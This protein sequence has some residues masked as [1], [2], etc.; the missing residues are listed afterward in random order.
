MVCVK[1]THD[2]WRAASAKDAYVLFER[3]F[4][5]LRVRD[6]FSEEEM[7]RFA[8]EKP[9]SF[10]P[11]ERPMSL[12]GMF[13]SENE[14]S[15]PSGVLFL[16]DSA[17][18]FPPDTA[19]GIN[20]ALEDVRVLKRVLED[21]GDKGSLTNALETYEKR[22]DG[23]IWELM[24]LAEKSSPYQYQQNWMGYFGY[25]LNKTVRA[26]LSGFAPALFHPDADTLI[27]QDYEYSQVRRL[28]DSTTRNMV[29]LSLSLVALPL[30]NMVVSQ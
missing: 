1:P 30:M 10:S 18:S 21:V 17:H 12:V 20:C 24:R 3:N 14:H 29:V 26:T 4:P 23:E 13:K 9:M 16:G 5:Q 28:S 27:R 2:L 11:I 15:K 19:Q 25:M 6:M 8:S 22:R 7:T